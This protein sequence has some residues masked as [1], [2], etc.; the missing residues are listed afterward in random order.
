MASNPISNDRAVHLVFRGR[1]HYRQGRVI[2]QTIGDV[3]RALGERES[4]S[5]SETELF[6]AGFNAEQSAVTALAV[7]MTSHTE[8]SASGSVNLI[9]STDPTKDTSH[10]PSS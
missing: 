6:I 5:N 3:M 10:D 8:K 1:V 2:P 7:L 9:P 4:I